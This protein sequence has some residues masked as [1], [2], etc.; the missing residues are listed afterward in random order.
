MED[1][2]KSLIA[3]CGLILGNDAIPLAMERQLESVLVVVA[4]GEAALVCCF[5]VEFVG[6]LHGRRPVY[7]R[8]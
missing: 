5:I 2:W 1:T 4:A 3:F 6:V 7:Q 8:S